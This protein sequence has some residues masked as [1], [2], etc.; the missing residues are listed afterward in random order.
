VIFTRYQQIAMMDESTGELT[1]RR[2][3]RESWEAQEFY[4]NLPR[5]VRVRIEATGLVHSFEGLLVELGHELWIGD[6][7]KIRA[8]Q[9]AES[10]AELPQDEARQTCVWL[11]HRP[12]FLH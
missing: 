7:A 9:V 12:G 10:F 8:R 4:R 11:S 6:A 2:L 3:D 5:P 1:E